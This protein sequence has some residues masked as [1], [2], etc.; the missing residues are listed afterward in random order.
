MDR[1]REKDSRPLKDFNIDF[2]PLSCVFLPSTFH[3]LSSSIAQLSNPHKY[4]PKLITSNNFTT[5]SPSVPNSLSIN[6]PPTSHL[7]KQISK[8][9]PLTAIYIP[10]LHLTTGIIRFP[11]AEFGSLSG[12][13]PHACD[14]QVPSRALISGSRFP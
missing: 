8:L 14:V 1:H 12:L 13:M 11:P 10:F 2:Q 6:K 5:R 4:Y 3:F 9:S 7:P